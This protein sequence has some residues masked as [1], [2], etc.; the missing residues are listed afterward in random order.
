MGAIVVYD[1]TNR[2]SYR[3]VDSWIRE[4]KTFSS[5]PHCVLVLLGNK[6]DLSTARQVTVEEAT[7]FAKRHEMSFLETSALDS[8]N[9]TRAFQ[10]TLKGTNIIWSHY[11]GIISLK[12]SS[13]EKLRNFCI[14]DVI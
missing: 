6:C 12:S 7:D 1:I 8:T 13:V 9:V 5:N 14:S 2:N 4:I 11:N 10:M 3:R